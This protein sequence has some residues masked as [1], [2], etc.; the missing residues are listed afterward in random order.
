M[1]SVKSIPTD[2]TRAYSTSSSFNLTVL[3]SGS[4]TNLQALIDACGQAPPS[5]NKPPP[6]R[7]LPHAE[8]NHVISNR[9]EAY[10]LARA[11]DAHIPVTY[12]N[13]MSYK[14]KH[15][16][17]EEG[18]RAAR[19]HYDADLAQ[20][21]LTHIPCPDLVICAGWMHILS[22]TFINAL[23]SAN[24]PII[25]LHP[26]LPGKFNGADAIGRAYE[27]F[28]R[29]E[30]SNTGVMVHYVVDE[31]DMG[32]PVLVKEVEIK[33]EDTQEDLEERIHQVEWKL[34]VEAT[35]KVL[36]ELEEKRRSES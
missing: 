5:K 6:R 2:K 10:G 3:I 8:I 1:A 35:G 28:Q 4:G 31:V 32:Q 34:I 19:S 13:L 33:S 21:I 11:Q 15:P 30:I 24:V 17:T 26:A 20:K 22:P 27:A 25:N 9:R 14:K 12:H 7:T 23:S 16:D 18:I 29:G 36:A